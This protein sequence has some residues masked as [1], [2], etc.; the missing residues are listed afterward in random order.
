LLKKKA[1]STVIPLI[2]FSVGCA[3]SYLFSFFEHATALD[4]ERERI[5]AEL[6]MVRGDLSRELNVTIYLTQGINSLISVDGGVTGERFRG[7]AED[8]LKHSKLIRNVALAPDN[9]I[10]Y[11]YPLKGNEKA[12]G[13]DYMSLKDQRDSVLR[14]MSERR[15]VVAGPVNLVQGGV[16]IIGRQP[17][18]LAGKGGK[19]AYWGLLS[20]VVDFNRLIRASGIGVKPSHM[21]VALRGRDGT[22]SNG[23][24]FFGSPDIFTSQP[25]VMDV[26]LPSGSW[27]IAAIPK[28]G[29]LQFNPFA[30]AVFW[31][32]N[33]LS[34]AFS[35]LFLKVLRV[36]RE[37]ALE[38]IE[39]KKIEDAL[40]RTNA[41]LE[42]ARD[43]L[44]ERVIE[45]TEELQSAK[46]RAESA[47]RI[48]S[49]FLATMSHELRTPLNSIIGFTGILLQGLAGSLNEE[50]SKQMG[51]VQ[52][53]A[54][55]LL[56]LINDVLDI[57]K[58]E[59]GQLQVVLA[60]IDLRKSV[61][62]VVATIS[63]LAN[64]KKLDLQVRL[65][66]KI[67]SARGDKL[68]VE[69]IL[70]NLLSNAVKFT[71]AGQIVI[72]GSLG[73][74]E[75]EIF[76]RDTGIGI[77][78]EDLSTL[79]KPFRQIDTGLARRHEGTG[80]GLFIC[81]RLLDLMGGSIRVES[82]A[83]RGSTF[84]ITLPL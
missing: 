64:R 81:K 25:V 9:V 16:G 84:T 68:R 53:S 15:T 56:A 78:P 6:D 13:V 23:D 61:E 39:R 76:V 22:G 80:L 8:L 83:G 33:G 1:A 58:I 45:R 51:M 14:A 57:S 4:R 44:E 75:V 47:D 34:F 48:K 26:P 49:A 10:R 50:Q 65:E 59:A 72:G 69:Q 40:R 37:M 71:D 24:C 19:T 18:F 55:H 3:L 42:H 27:Q 52:N 73:D 12:V 63:P 17:V 66:P 77:K 28:G 46:E 74:H 7:V 11:V 32:G 21:K 29:W 43:E 41:A 79:F 70:M 20:T 35:L 82:D 67:D 38:V 36:S 62:Q 54:R 31:L 2:L 60:T 30:S 5:L